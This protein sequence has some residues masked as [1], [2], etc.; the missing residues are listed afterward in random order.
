[1]V[2]DEDGVVLSPLPSQQEADT[3]HAA[4]VRRLLGLA[5]AQTL[6]GVRKELLKGQGLCLP[7]ARW[8]RPCADLVEQLVE[9]ALIALTPQAAQIR[10]L[11]DFD[12]LL[13]TIRSKVTGQIRDYAG[14]TQQLLQQGQQLLS[15]CTR[16]KT[17]TRSESIADI[18]AFIQ[19][20]LN[21]SFVI[22]MTDS[23][24]RDVPRYLK[25]ATY[26]LEKLT[27]NLP[28]DERRQDEY[29]DVERLMLQAKGLQQMHPE[30]YLQAQT[31]AIELWVAIFAQPLAL[32]GAASLKRLES[33]LA[34]KG[35][36]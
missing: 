10:A 34:I 11:E 6:N 22:D 26:R 25:A 33:I 7:W 9:R 17:P 16:L 3:A 2:L 20:R 5:L 23:G 24:W 14:Q 30:R 13:N 8:Q 4:G 1:L 21:P 32:K 27:E 29:N 12:A 18:E 15:D 31:M 19:Q 36:L 28:L 35:I